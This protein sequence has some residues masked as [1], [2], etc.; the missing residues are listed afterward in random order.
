MI[1]ESSSESDY[2][3]RLIEQLVQDCPRR[4]AGSRDERRAQDI[5]QAE[6]DRAGM[7]TRVEPF[8]FCDNLYR[9]IAL[10]FGA[11]LLGSVI[12][13]RAPLAALGL[14]VVG[15]SYWAHSTHRSGVVH[16]MLPRG[17]SQ[18]L[19]ATLPAEGI[20]A[21]RV[22]VAAHIDAGFTGVMFGSRLLHDLSGAMSGGGLDWLDQPLALATYSQL[23]LA[24]LDLLQLTG[25]ARGRLAGLLRAG[26][27]IPSLISF[28][29]SADVAQRD[30][31]VPGANDDLSG[32]AGALLLARRFANKKPANVELV[33]AITGAEEVG[34]AGAR[35][36]ADA[37]RWEPHN[38]VVVGLDGLSNGGLRYFVEGEVERVCV[39]E[40]LG[41]ILEQVAQ[42]EQ[43][44]NG[45]SSF[46]IPVGGTDVYAF[47]RRGFDGVCLGCV[48]P[49]L[50]TPRHYHQ[51]SD[52]PAHL[53]MA[54]LMLG[55]DF[56][57]QLIEHIIERRC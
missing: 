26:L 50:G 31:V 4:R 51:P 6:L 29:L 3:Y 45:V 49:A 25:R 32:V 44:F 55:V 17:R 54:E 27:T 38:T 42:S 7:P 5:V 37:G 15:A 10:H 11:G 19:L 9:V 40:W 30:H 18:N 1:R 34:L 47:R 24:G 8:D 48:D 23:A 53:D 28:L 33:F 35:A 2:A 20:P 21:L 14:H 41:Q 36:L 12:G 52:T 22:V 43:R 16:P 56:A 13:R 46:D 39:P 57:Q